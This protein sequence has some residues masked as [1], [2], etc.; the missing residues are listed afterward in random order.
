MLK[1]AK[2]NRAEFG[3]EGAACLARS[4]TF[5][6]PPLPESQ[7]QACVVLELVPP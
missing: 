5:R 3:D 1:R 7:E 4:N 6:S 2:K